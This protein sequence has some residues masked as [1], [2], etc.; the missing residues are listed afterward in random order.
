[1]FLFPTFG[2]ADA[3]PQMNDSPKP[4]FSHGRGLFAV[5]ALILLAAPLAAEP[6]PP[7]SDAIGDRAA[8]AI[9]EAARAEQPEIRNA[10]I[11]Q[12]LALLD[13]LLADPA[14]DQSSKLRS[15]YDRIVALRVGERYAEALAAFEALALT[16]EE[17]PIYVVEAA[18]DSW[19]ALRRPAR[20]DALYAVILVR[21]PD[22]FDTRMAR[23]WAL[24]ELERFDLALPWIDALVE[25][26]A[27]G[28]GAREHIESRR[29]AAMARAYSNRL[30][31]AEARLQVLLAEHPENVLVRR[32]L[33]TVQRWR[34]RPGQ[35]AQTLDAAPGGETDDS[36]GTRLLRAHLLADRGRL[37]AADSAF[38][39]VERVAPGN[40][41]VQRDVAGW[42]ERRR[43][44]VAIDAGYGDSTGVE[45]FG[46]RDRTLGVRINAPSVAPGVQPYLLSRY[47]D[48]T[49]PEGRAEYDRVGLG[50]GLQHGAHRGALELH[51]NR[52]GGNTGLTAAYDLRAGDHLSFGTRFESFSTDVPLRARGQDI[53]G[54]KAELGSRWQF[55]EAAAI[56]MNI[57]RLELTDGNLRWAALMAYSHELHASA[58]RQTRGSFDL[59]GSDAQQGGGPYFN[60]SRDA[61]AYYQV[62][63]DWLTW[64][65]YERSFTQRFIGGGGG[66]WQKA[67]GTFAIGGL[68]YEHK[69]VFSARW[70]LRYGIGLSSRVYDGNRERRLDGQLAIEGVF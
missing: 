60:P 5:L 39:D 66:Y 55:D 40:I 53:E 10:R 42:R 4:K 14:V 69:W 25:N 65:R 64:R 12:A 49:F 36:A 62:E 45:R 61:S 26:T 43:W 68:R 29:I 20:A 34:G 47:A 9:R 31:A 70:Q 7:A 52:T 56:R 38:E 33:A 11:A 24:L 13:G 41:H 37:T 48:A 57:S 3:A 15:R 30:D 50:L 67:F 28:P 63:H 18:A 23:F 35:A 19:L 22:R 54:W 27:A 2:V 51:R 6:A 1:M 16:P 58:H 17:L 8:T 44:S 32:D 21:E 59:Y 46:A